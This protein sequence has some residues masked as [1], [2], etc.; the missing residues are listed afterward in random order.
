MCAVRN[1]F[2]PST[3]RLCRVRKRSNLPRH[4]QWEKVFQSRGWGKNCA[5]VA[6]PIQA[7]RRLV[8]ESNMWTGPQGQ[9]KAGSGPG[10][11]HKSA[12]SFSQT[13]G[14]YIKVHD[15]RR[16]RDQGV[17]EWEWKRAKK[18][19]HD[20]GSPHVQGEIKLDVPS[21]PPYSCNAISDWYTTRPSGPPATPRATTSEEEQQ[22]R[23]SSNR[24]TGFETPAIRHLGRVLSWRAS[25]S[26]DHSKW[27]SAGRARCLFPFRSPYLAS[28]ASLPDTPLQRSRLSG[29]LCSRAPRSPPPPPPPA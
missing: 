16:S 26:P 20:S 2:G 24:T 27:N 14:K 4:S 18:G 29:L 8:A 19:C 11:S 25:R 10:T 1:W 6:R 12:A 9:V 22:R 23:D 7:G 5:R 28:S 17:G 13:S 3:A 21:M 15:I